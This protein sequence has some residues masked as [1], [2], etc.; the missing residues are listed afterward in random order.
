M[1][2][3]KRWFILLFTIVTVTILISSVVYFFYGFSSSSSYSIDEELEGDEL[4]RAKEL[5]R[6]LEANPPGRPNAVHKI[7]PKLE[8]GLVFD[9][10]EKLNKS[11][12]VRVMHEMTHQKISADKKYGAILMSHENIREVRAYLE[13][14][15]KKNKLN[16]NDYTKLGKIIEQWEQADFSNIDKD[17]DYILDGM[18]AKIGYSNGLATPEEEELFILNNFGE[19][20]VYTI[21]L[22][23]MEKA[24][25]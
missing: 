16:L 18:G 2:K 11:N 6:F 17:Q 20:Y 4:D 23:P 19:K 22:K 24:E 13:L 15:R 10:L 14:A 12:L 5:K 1:I 8:T 9:D 25:N 3:K 21:N 7:N